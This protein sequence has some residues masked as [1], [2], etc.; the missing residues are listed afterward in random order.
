MAVGT[1]NQVLY[2]MTNSRSASLALLDQRRQSGFPHQREE[3][4][5]HHPI[6]IIECRL[7]DAEQQAG[8]ALDTLQFANHLGGNSLLGPDRDPMDNLDEEIHESIGDFSSA[9]PAGAD[10]SV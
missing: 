3:Y 7:G 6:R 10:S 2:S 5:A 4:V 9:L 1:V 8:L